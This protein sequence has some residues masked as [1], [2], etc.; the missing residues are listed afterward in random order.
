MITQS[1]LLI[2]PFSIFENGLSENLFEPCIVF[3]REEDQILNPFAP[4]YSS[5]AET[6]CILFVAY[7][8]INN[9]K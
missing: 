5:V 7:I 1:F 9:I 8:T 6:T 4:A 2:L 3:E